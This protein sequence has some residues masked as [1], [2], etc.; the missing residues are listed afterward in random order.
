MTEH[1][2]LVAVA[3]AEVAPDLE[4]GLQLTDSLARDA[5]A[6]G[7]RL[8]VFPETWLP[9]YPVWLDVCRDAG[10]WNHPPVKTVFAR[11]A[12]NSVA[13]PSPELEHLRETARSCAATL[14]I[15]VSERVDKG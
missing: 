10:L 1:T 2:L 12:A 13:V 14:V 6:Q 7:A 15:G 5:A 8:V 4:S 3:Q 9:G 11:L